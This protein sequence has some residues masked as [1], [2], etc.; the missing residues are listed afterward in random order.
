MKRQQQLG[1]AEPLLAS[2]A[3][4]LLRGCFGRRGG[5]R[6]RP[7]GPRA[8][9]LSE[10]HVRERALQLPLRIL[11]VALGLRLRRRRRGDL[12]VR[13]RI[14]VSAPWF[15]RG[16]QKKSTTPQL[17]SSSPDSSEALADSSWRSRLLDVEAMEAPVRRRLSPLMAAVAVAVA[18]LA[19][20]ARL[21]FERWCASAT[22]QA[23]L[24]NGDRVR[25]ASCRK[26]HYDVTVI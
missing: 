2:P 9:Q 8:L 1:I 13:Q 23:G 4:L 22:V 5:P 17:T 20:A 7:V 14:L 12:L 6:Q 10:G 24:R 26:N 18:G 3:S 19:A 25:A 21:C 15:V 16:G 11:A